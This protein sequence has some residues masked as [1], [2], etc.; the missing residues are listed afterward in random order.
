MSC[1][2]WIIKQQIK[3][4]FGAATSFVFA[5]WLVWCLTAWIKFINRSKLFWMLKYV[6]LIIILSFVHYIAIY[7][8]LLQKTIFVMT[9]IRKNK[10]CNYVCEYPHWSADLPKYSKFDSS[11]CLVNWLIRSYASTFELFYNIIL[12]KWNC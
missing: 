7:W 2:F 6:L 11:T 9:R 10:C 3:D 8:N 4:P 12:I 5:S 1:S